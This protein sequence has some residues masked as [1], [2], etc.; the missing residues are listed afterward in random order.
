METFFSLGVVALSFIA[1]IFFGWIGALIVFLSGMLVQYNNERKH[2]MEIE[3]AELLATIRSLRIN[4][5]NENES[6][7]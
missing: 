1:F 3:K 7:E 2:E 6:Y 4:Q 5:K